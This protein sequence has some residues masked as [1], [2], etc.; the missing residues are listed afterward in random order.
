MPKGRGKYSGMSSKG[1][2]AGSV[3]SAY[4]RRK[5]RHARINAYRASQRGNYKKL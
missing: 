4:R 1:R 3:D 5:A 2:W